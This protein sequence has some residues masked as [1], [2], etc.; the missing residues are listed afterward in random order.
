MRAVTYPARNEIAITDR[1]D[2]HAQD[3]QIVVAVRAAGLNRADLLQRTGNYPAPPGWPADIPGLEY[4][5]DVIG[6]GS[7]ETRFRVGDRVMGLVGG[8]AHAEQVVV[9]ELE[10]MAIPD[11][12]TYAEAAAIPEAFL[13]AWDALVVRGRTQPGERVLVHAVGSG[14]GTAAVQLGQLCGATVVGSSRTA[15]KLRRATALGMHAGVDT[16]AP[17]WPSRVGEAVDVIIDTLGGSAL[18]D[19]LRLLAVRGRLV[20]LGLLAGRTASDV[21]LDN[22]LRR[23]LEIIGSVMRTRNLSERVEL[24][25]RF[26]VDVLPH[27]AT[28]TLRPVVHAILPMEAIDDAHQTMSGNATFGKLVLTW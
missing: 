5:G 22:I 11:G 10:A 27:F 14:V 6:T 9:D 26:G 8:G 2:L 1:P 12:L 18:R 23:R 28:G 16:S 17:D 19:N 15:D 20:L 3:G 25:A 4:A 24:V 7:G 13:T 21:E